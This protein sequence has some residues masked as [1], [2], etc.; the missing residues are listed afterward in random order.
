MR[1]PVVDAAIEA[2][3]AAHTTP[4][5]PYMAEAA[6]EGNELAPNMLTGQLEGR[7]LTFLV[8]MLGARR[9]LDVGTFTGYS[10]LSI[11]EGMGPDGR[12]ITLEADEKHVGIAR[13]H[14]AASPHAAKI[15]LRFGQALESMRDLEGRFDFVFI[16]ADKSN[17]LAYYDRAVELLAPA[18]LIAIDN[19]LWYQQVLNPADGDA[20]TSLMVAFNDYVVNDLRVECVMLTVR[21]GLTLVRKRSAS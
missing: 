2:Y 5:P 9:A 18:A 19:T 17:Y 15:D 11:A 1:K 13:R 14:F 3:A 21:D 16:D 20:D 8:Q 12:V 10:A 4:E 6:R 7:L